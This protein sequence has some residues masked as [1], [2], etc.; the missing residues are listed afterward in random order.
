MKHASMLIFEA[1][2]FAGKL[3]HSLHYAEAFNS[4]TGWFI[5][6]WCK[7]QDKHCQARVSSRHRNS[8]LGSKIK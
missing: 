1:V 3:W 8:F 6:D 5:V 7:E 2:C 4:S